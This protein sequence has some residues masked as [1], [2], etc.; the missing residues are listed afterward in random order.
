MVEMRCGHRTARRDWKGGRHVSRA[1]RDALVDELDGEPEG[2][3]IL[4]PEPVQEGSETRAGDNGWRLS[5]P[6]RGNP[7]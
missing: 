4:M 6:D 3:W 5:G 2:E 7:E 1:E